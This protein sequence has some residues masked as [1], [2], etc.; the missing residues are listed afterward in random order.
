MASS[1][2]EELSLTQEL[3]PLQELDLP[4]ITTPA[5][6]PAID[7]KEKTVLTAKDICLSPKQIHTP[8]VVRMKCYKSRLWKFAQMEVK[9]KFDLHGNPTKG[10]DLHTKVTELY[11]QLLQ[12]PK[13]LD[14]LNKE[15]EHR[16][17][18]IAYSKKEYNRRYYSLEKNKQR[19]AELGK[20]RRRLAAQQ[21]LEKKLNADVVE[22]RFPPT[23]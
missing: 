14:I 21:A 6:P 5:T 9:A 1:S 11:Q 20:K 13:H 17:A 12:D 19:R 8:A 16:K 2:S 3:S 15:E 22:P 10:T 18:R 4:A 7:L 23:P